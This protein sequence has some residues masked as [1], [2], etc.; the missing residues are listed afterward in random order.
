MTDTQVTFVVDTL[1]SCW[2][3]FVE[4]TGWAL[5][6]INTALCNRC[7]ICVQHCSTH[8]VEMGPEGP[9]IARPQDCDY[10]ATCDA[11]CPQGAITCAYEIVWGE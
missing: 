7:G 8:A 2:Y 3:N 9:Y 4:M 10:C 5:P 11:I 1:P 6:E